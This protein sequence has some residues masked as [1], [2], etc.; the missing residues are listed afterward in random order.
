MSQQETPQKEAQAAPK[1]GSWDDLAAHPE[2][3]LGWEALLLLAGLLQRFIPAVSG[4]VIIAVPLVLALVILPGVMAGVVL[5]KNRATVTDS[6]RAIMI[7]PAVIC[8]AFGIYLLAW[9]LS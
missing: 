6:G 4:V 5:Y 7:I 1:K 8:T 3:V 9:S 2:K